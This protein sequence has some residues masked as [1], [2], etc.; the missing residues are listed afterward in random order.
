MALTR[1]LAWALLALAGPALA[2]PALLGELQAQAPAADPK[3]LA[4]ALEA[5]ECAAESAPSASRLAVID[6]SRPSTEPRLWVFDLERRKLLYAEHVAHGRGSGENLPT[7]FSNR[8]GSHQS[9]LGL[10]VTA[11]T[12]H[13]GNGYSLRMDGLEPGV[14]D[15]ARERLIVMHGAPY[16]DPLTAALQGRLGRSFG[17][18][19]VRPEVAREMIDTLKQGQLVFAYYPDEDWLGSSRFIGCRQGALARARAGASQG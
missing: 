1:D 7:T 16:V 18:P 15:A 19:A 2:E 14:N 10:F 17:C 6:Y 12:Y 4:L 5:R 13:G 11:E 8:N 9:S 3:V